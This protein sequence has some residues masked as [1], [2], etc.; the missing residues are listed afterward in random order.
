VATDSHAQVK[1]LGSRPDGGGADVQ[2]HEFF[3]GVN[4]RL[5]ELR[6]VRTCASSWM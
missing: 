5:L 2:Q 3:K 6:Q 4:W 1:R